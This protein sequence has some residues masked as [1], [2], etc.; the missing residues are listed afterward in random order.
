MT[1]RI[2]TRRHRAGD[3]DVY[4]DGRRIGYLYQEDWTSRRPWRITLN[5]TD[6]FRTTIPFPTKKAALTHLR[7]SLKDPA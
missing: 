6:G 7:N 3:Y 5:F 1:T 4:V 2:T